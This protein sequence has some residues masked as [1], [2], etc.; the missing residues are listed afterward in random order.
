MVYANWARNGGKVP[1][2][3]G[4]VLDSWSQAVG[5]VAASMSPSSFLDTPASL[6][7]PQVQ[8]PAPRGAC[9]EHGHRVIPSSYVVGEV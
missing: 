6:H 1:F 4:A 7:H 5:I 3:V 2:D 8:S 9:H